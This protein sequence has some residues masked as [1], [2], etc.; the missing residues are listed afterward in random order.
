MRK[1]ISLALIP[2]VLLVC[3]AALFAAPVALENPGTPVWRLDAKNVSTIPGN[4][5][6]SLDP[7]KNKKF[8]GELPSR[9]GMYSLKISGSAMFSANQL[10]NLIAEIRTVH[11]GPIVIMDL[12][13]E[14]HG[15]VNGIAV[16]SYTDRNWINVGKSV[17]QV[18]KEEKA[19][20]R[21]SLKGPIDISALDD[22]KKVSETLKASVE[23]ALT[24]KEL[25]TSREIGYFRLQAT[26]HASFTD[27]QVDEFVK[28]YK[29]ELP[30]DAWLHF[31]CFAGEGRTTQLMVMYD[32]LR[33]GKNVSLEDIVKRQYLIGGNDAM[34]VTA[35]K[36]KDAYKVPLYKEKAQMLKDFYQYVTTSPDDLPVS[37]SKWKKAQKADDKVATDK[38]ATDKPAKAKKK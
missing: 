30:K 24:E 25:V 5:R 17:A 31:H 1:I 8:N 27:E 19:W 15:Y 23:T 6:T 9:E 26:D 3:Q 13:Q 2:A 38:P 28:F 22:D 18:E 34:K 11:Q 21:D 29:K 20:L 33:N 16:S 37:F 35:S 12:R 7:F 36:E 4:F 14:S 10:D 32:I